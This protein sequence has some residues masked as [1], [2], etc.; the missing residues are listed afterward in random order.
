MFIKINRKLD[1][2]PILVN[3]EAI[4]SIVEHRTPDETFCRIS[5]KDSEEIID[6]KHTLA[7]F[8]FLLEVNSIE[9][10]I[11]KLK[12]ENLQLQGQI[13]YQTVHDELIGGRKS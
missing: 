7:N 8:E 12:L 1:G 2:E 3:T 9:R 5:F 4:A 6:V 11:A 10:Q 13:M